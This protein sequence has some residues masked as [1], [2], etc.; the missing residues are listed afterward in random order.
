[1]SKIRLNANYGNDFT[2]THKGFVV[3]KNEW[4]EYEDDSD[5]EIEHLKKDNF[6]ETFDATKQSTFESKFIAEKK[7]NEELKKEIV[8]LKKELGDVPK[9]NPKSDVSKTDIKKD[10]K[11]QT[12][13]PKN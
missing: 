11:L 3:R 8:K 12:I 4:T 5:F 10:D 2:T 9:E 6:I 1:M 7:I 13:T